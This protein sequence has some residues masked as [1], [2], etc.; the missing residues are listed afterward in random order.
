MV[1]V[2]AAAAAATVAAAAVSMTVMV[3]D[4]DL[5]GFGNVVG[6][7]L[8]LLLPLSMD[9]PRGGVLIGLFFLVGGRGKFM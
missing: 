6:G 7:R 3:A 2:A 5:T 1:T 4:R 8:L 9:R